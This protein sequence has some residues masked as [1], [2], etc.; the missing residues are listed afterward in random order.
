LHVADA[1]SPAREAQMATVRAVLEE[2]GAGDVPQLLVYNKIDLSCRAAGV[3]RDACDSIVRVFVSAAS[4][5][6][7]ELLRSTIA[8]RARSARTA[9]DEPAAPVAAHL[10]DAP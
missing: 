6:G 2:I 4:G 10:A 7:L 1:A 9:S 3:E 5:A 8:E